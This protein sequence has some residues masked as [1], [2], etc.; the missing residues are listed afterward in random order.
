MEAGP[1]SP[2]RGK[3]NGAGHT[4][5]AMKQAQALALTDVAEPLCI[6]SGRVEGPSP[7][8][9]VRA[10]GEATSPPLRCDARPLTSAQLVL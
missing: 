8:G 1:S 4:V 5:G 9:T 7:L 6:L 10:C 3:L 2:A